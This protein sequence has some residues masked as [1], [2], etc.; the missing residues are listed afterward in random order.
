MMTPWRCILT[1]SNPWTM[2]TLCMFAIEVCCEVVMCMHRS[3]G[4][5]KCHC[6]YS[7]DGSHEPEHILPEC[8]NAWLRSRTWRWAMGGPWAGCCS[9][10]QLQIKDSQEIKGQVVLLLL[11]WGPCFGIYFVPLHSKRAYFVQGLQSWAWE[12]HC[13]NQVMTLCVCIRCSAEVLALAGKA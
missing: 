4:C 2:F 3:T 13:A 6:D 9:F 1:N 8:G 10:N 5:C 11:C 12:P 7:A